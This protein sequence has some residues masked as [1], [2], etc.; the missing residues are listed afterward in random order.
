MADDWTFRHRLMLGDR[1][2]INWAEPEMQLTNADDSQTVYLKS[3]MGVPI[4][5]TVDL[6]LR[7]W[8]YES[9]EAAQE[10]AGRWRSAVTIGLAA[11]NVGSDF[12]MRSPA[13][14]MDPTF[15]ASHSVDGEPVMQDEFALMIFRTETAP[16]FMGFTAGA[17][18]VGK[19][20]D[21][22]RFAIQMA[23]SEGTELTDRQNLTYAV[24]ASSFGLRPD[25]RLVALVSAV[26][27]MTN[28]Q[29]RDAEAQTVV[30]SMVKTIN[31]SGMDP[32]TKDSMKGALVWLRRQSIKQSVKDVALTLGDRKYMGESA[33]K[34]LLRCY[35][36]R[37]T[38]VHGP[39]LPDWDEVNV[40][41]G[42]LERVV[43][44]LIAIS[45]VND[46]GV[47]PGPTWVASHASADW[48]GDPAAIPLEGEAI[49]WQT[50]N[51]GE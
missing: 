21:E 33:A 47:I 32:S 13:S 23:L 19:G 43:G 37:S 4:Q 45:I 50:E 27:L 6:V 51:D 1:M 44:D 34:F 48:D 20:G 17:V 46:A 11:H 7:G 35:D 28:P 29:D 3:R 42:E 15:M 8:G 22:V 40:R 9:P 38:L 30:D 2:R 41:G 25:A 12:G 16:R 5:D 18:T 36:L 14:W 24:Y 49:T 31:A 26:E 39:S 10:A